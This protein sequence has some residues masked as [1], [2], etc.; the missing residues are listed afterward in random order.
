MTLRTRIRLIWI[1]I[2]VVVTFGSFFGA[3]ALGWDPVKLALILLI[4]LLLALV[5]VQVTLVRGAQQRLARAF[6]TEDLPAM[7][8]ELLQL[9][10]Y[11]RDQPRMRELLR[12]AEASAF[13]AEEKHAEARAVLESIDQSIL[14]EEALPTI[15]NNLAWCMAH[16]GEHERAIEMARAAVGRADGQSAATVANLLGTL[17]VCY[18]LGGRAQEAVPILQKALGRGATA[19]PPQRQ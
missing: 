16:L 7:R 13:V 12:M 11:F 10:D 5:A 4:P 3:R 15:Q 1:A 14:G 17:G 18:V 8:H 6:A 9:I 19:Q 2:T